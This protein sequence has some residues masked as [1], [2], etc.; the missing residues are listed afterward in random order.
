MSQRS[1][2]ALHSL[3]LQPMQLLPIPAQALTPSPRTT[4]LLCVI[5]IIFVMR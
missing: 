1:I 4:T 2:E 5:S 3:L